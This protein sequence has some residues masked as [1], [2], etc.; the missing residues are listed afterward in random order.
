MGH[1]IAEVSS[2]VGKPVEAVALLRRASKNGLPNYPAFRDD[3]HFRVMQNHPQYLRL[4][5]DLK[6]EWESYRHEFG[7]A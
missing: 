5:A 6:R 1:T 7:H 4:L 3:P 2:L